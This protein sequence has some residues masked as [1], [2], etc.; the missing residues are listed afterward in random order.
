M[1]GTAN[2]VNACLANDVGSLLYLST[3]YA[4]GEKKEGDVWNESAKWAN[5]KLANG[6]GWSKHLAEREIWRGA[7]EGLRTFIVNPGVILSRTWSDDYSREVM[8]LIVKGQSSAI[9]GSAHFVDVRDLV[10]LMTSL[11]GSELGAAQYVVKGHVRKLM[12]LA[13]QVEEAVG[14]SSDSIAGKGQPLQVKHW[15][16]RARRMFETKDPRLT[17]ATRKVLSDNREFSGER[18]FR[19]LTVSFRPLRDSLQWSCS[20]NFAAR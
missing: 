19:D 17:K 4:F 9:K 15:L 7:A 12:D 5:K 18:L 3:I 13:R 8:Q 20:G 16:Q 6:Y 1:T 2:V 10:L 14:P 11:M